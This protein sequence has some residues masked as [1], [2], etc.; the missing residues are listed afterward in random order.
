MSTSTDA[1]PIKGPTTAEESFPT[2]GLEGNNPVSKSGESGVGPMDSTMTMTNS[3][4]AGA[5]A[6]L[7]VAGYEGNNGCGIS[8]SENGSTG[9]LIVNEEFVLSTDS[10]VNVSSMSR[11]DELD[12]DED[13]EDGEDVDNDDDGTPWPPQQHLRGNILTAATHRRKRSGSGGSNSGGRANPHTHT[14]VKY[15]ANHHNHGHHS[16]N[17]NVAP[18]VIHAHRPHG[19]QSSP[20]QDARKH[21]YPA[22]PADKWM[23]VVSAD[24]P[25][26]ALI[27]CEVAVINNLPEGTVIIFCWVNEQGRLYHYRHILPFCDGCTSKNLH[28]ENGFTNH[29][30][31]GYAQR[32]HQATNR[33]AHLRDVDPKVCACIMSLSRVGFMCMVL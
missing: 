1:N 12:I 3:E 9:I 8:R 23:S 17:N 13:N 14:D 11:A 24:D 25:D 19:H 30:F 6:A 29:V 22:K 31:V 32:S 21:E 7:A 4:D 16:G 33:P 15:T 18:A 10:Y 20:K 27:E 2:S 28:K 26:A 5:G